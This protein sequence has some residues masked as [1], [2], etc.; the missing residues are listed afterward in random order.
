MRKISSMKKKLLYVLTGIIVVSGC[1]YDKEELL[2]PD[3]I[4]CATVPARFSADVNPIIQSRCAIS[5]CHAAGSTNGRGPL[6][7]YDLIKNAAVEIKA[8]VV[9]KF[10]PQGSSLTPIEIKTISC[11]VDAGAPNN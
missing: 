7:S 3:G 1:Y 8:A 5:G 11:W 4:N 9:S 6:T 2:Y 10:M